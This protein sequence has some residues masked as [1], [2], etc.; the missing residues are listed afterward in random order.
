MNTYISF[1]LRYNRILVFVSSLR[2]IGCPHRICFMISSDGKSLLLMP[3]GKRDFVSHSVSY[4]VYRG[5]G[6]FTVHSMKLCRILAEMHHWDP[7]RSY[8]I[9]GE[10][11]RDKQL[12]IFNLE[13]AS[14]IEQ[15][16]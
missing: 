10:I 7:Q 8:R 6:G 14:M 1:Y 12:V 5:T 3:H 9:P 4:E 2:A 13:S 11:H 15:A 16:L